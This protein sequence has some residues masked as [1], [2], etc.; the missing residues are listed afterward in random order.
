MLKQRVLSIVMSLALVLTLSFAST[1]DEVAVTAGSSVQIVSVLGGATEVKVI[2]LFNN[3]QEDQVVTVLCE[4][5]GSD[6]QTGTELLYV[7]EWDG[8][9]Q[10]INVR[11]FPVNS[12]DAEG[13][14]R[15]I[16]GGANVTNPFSFLFTFGAA[17]AQGGVAIAP[18]ATCGQVLEQMGLTDDIAIIAV[19]GQPLGREEKVPSGAVLTIQIDSQEITSL[20]YVAGDVSLDQ[21]I[22]ASDALLVLQ[23]SV[24]II[25]LE[26]LPSYAADVNFNGSINAS[27]ALLILQY[28]VGIIGGF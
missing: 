6:P 3:P 21:K 19:D 18:D 5:E 25:T 1:A 9:V 2:F 15:V 7:G 8:I 23:H 13:S 10:G 11:T 12:A 14:Y 4:R 22:D 27:D 24:H 17:S 26:R 28:S 16:L 20:L